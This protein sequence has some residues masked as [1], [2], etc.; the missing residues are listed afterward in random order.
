MSFSATGLLLCSLLYLMLLFGIAWVTERGMLPRH[1]VR[2][3]LVYSL[4]LGV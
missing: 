1:W 4:S 3:R 2:H